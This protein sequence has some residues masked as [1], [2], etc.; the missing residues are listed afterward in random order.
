VIRRRALKIASTSATII[1]FLGFI[2][3]VIWYIKDRDVHPLVWSIL[4]LSGVIQA[5]V[6]AIPTANIKGAWNYAVK[7]GDMERS[8]SGDCIVSLSQGE[9]HIRG[10]RRN[11]WLVKDKK[12]SY[13][14]VDYEWNTGWCEIC[15]DGFLRFHYSICLPEPIGRLEAV[16]RVQLFTERDWRVTSRME[17]AFWILPPLKEAARER[18]ICEYGNIVFTRKTKDTEEVIEPFSDVEDELDVIK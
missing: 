9:I 5:V 14:K 7:T 8:H 18:N 15:N 16:C 1:F 4:L 10:H 13:R 17:G 3:S 11:T 2:G 12:K 6:R